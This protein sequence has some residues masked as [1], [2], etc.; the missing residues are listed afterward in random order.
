MSAIDLRAANPIQIENAKPGTGEWRLFSEAVDGEVEG[1]AS[2]TSVNQG[3]S[4]SF[5]V[6]STAPQYNIDIF[7]TGWYGG[8]GGRRVANT[9]TRPGFVQTMPTPDPVTGLIECNWTDPYTITIPNDWVSGAY[10]VKLTT[11]GGPSV[12]NKY[13]LFVVRE[14]TRIANHNFQIT[15]STAQAY[16]S[17]GGK[18]L[19]GTSPARKVSFNR[20]YTDGSGTG[21]FMW[22]W[23]YNAIR[24]LEREG[25]DLT[26]TTNIDTHRRGHLLRNAKSFLSIGH[27]EYWS[28][29]MR[30]NVE[31]ALANGVNLGFFSA[32]N[33]Y[34]QVRFEPS[35]IDG[36]PDRTMVGYK[37]AALALD[38]YA[39]DNDP[40]NDN[41]ITTLWRDPPVNRPESALL[42]VQYIYYPVNA[43]IVIDDVE[44]EPWVF[45]ETG[46]S[47]GSSLPGVLG[48]E[49]DAMNE[50]T[51]PNTV[52]L[53][54]SPFD[55]NGTTMYSDMTIY[56]AGA[57][58]VFATGSIQW[59]WALDDWNGRNHPGAPVSHGVQQITR[60]L[61][62]KFAGT[63]AS[64]DCQITIDATSAA[65]GADAGSGTIALSTASHCGW[66][67]SSNAPWL[68]VSGE[69]SGS[70]NRTITYHYSSN[71]GSPARAADL[72]IGDKT[73][74]LQQANGCAYSISPQSASVGVAGGTVT[75][76][77]A[78]TSVCSWTA[79]TQ[80]SW[81]TVI[82][83]GSGFGNASVTVS[84]ERN[85]GPSRDAGVYLNGTYFNVHQ[86]GGCTYSAQPGS[87]A[88][89]AAGGEGLVE[90]TTHGSCFWSASTNNSWIV[91]S[92][93]TSGQGSGTVAYT[94]H[95]NSTGADRV[96]LIV[97]AGVNITVRQ[98][99][100]NCL[101]D[102]APLWASHTSAAETGT[103][104]VSSS[105]CPFEAVVESG[106]HFITIT[107]TT[108]TTVNY[109]VA[110]NA[111]ATARSG[112]I[113][114]S[115]R[116]V[117]ITQNGAGQAIFGLTAT[118]TST[119]TASLS[120]A[121]VAG[122]TGYEVYRSS[123]GGS[124]GL[125]TG[126]AVPPT[127]TT[128]A[129]SGLVANR[130]YIYRVR[131]LGTA[132]GVVAYSNLDPATTI[133]FTDPAILPGVTLVKAIHI[134]QL[135]TAV[136][137]MRAAGLLTSQTFQDPSLIGIQIKG[138]HIAQLRGALNAARAA[139]GLP[140]ISYTDPGLSIVRASHVTDLRA[141]VR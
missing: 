134:L 131:A 117:H 85:E 5:F 79:T 36:A 6:S 97:A 49:V 1:Y 86:S 139:I 120:W 38:P 124:L 39:L 58:W 53:G 8:H 87:V 51:P 90:V 25:Y 30:T 99:A 89:P 125:V 108:P 140:P 47:T 23:E 92:S 55:A 121:A 93:P 41:R 73:F 141:G 10:L 66:T 21:I 75:F 3:E 72:T 4:I 88:L 132:G 12:K 122:A 123:N 113:R 46:L 96:G 37:S 138:V 81:L 57:A 95:A 26:Y 109:S 27:D 17:W 127:S 84:A 98:T 9:V 19:Y 60:N 70:G 116:S 91:L 16:N 133:M 33:V 76:E 15:V 107:S 102:V 115:G 63:S 35:T 135:R 136:N 69:M 59:A 112:S 128:Y 110:Q 62:R 61:L 31:T 100:T 104:S 18:S 126:T 103:I 94:V 114:I 34:W 106:S 43:A 77:I 45:E 101:F 32:N 118:A 129:D 22:R 68:T 78:T 20:P 13:I 56:H 54:H 74:T 24:F 67:I 65:V 28:W 83:P 52:R 50:F 119:S 29:E 71:A 48:Y 111:S 82:S 42:G 130:T 11:V 7:R 14:D 64:V 80:A 40:S 2:A 105:A 137:A 44:S